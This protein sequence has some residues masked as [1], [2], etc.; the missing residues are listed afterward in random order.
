MTLGSAQAVGNWSS[1]RHRATGAP[2]HRARLS[3]RPGRSKAAR[4]SAL[5]CSAGLAVRYRSTTSSAAM[6]PGPSKPPGHTRPGP[7]NEGLP[8]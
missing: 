2:K 8:K 5:A 4:C 1:Y 7:T 6:L 3:E